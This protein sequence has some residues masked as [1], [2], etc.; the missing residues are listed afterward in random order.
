[1]GPEGHKRHYKR[2]FDRPKGLFGKNK[3][4]ETPCTYKE[5]GRSGGGAGS[6]KEKRELAG[7]G[8]LE[9]SGGAEGGALTWEPDY[10]KKETHPNLLKAARENRRV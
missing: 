7:V 3:G 6:R 5:G 2:V 9:M 10:G 1:M 8:R 4:N